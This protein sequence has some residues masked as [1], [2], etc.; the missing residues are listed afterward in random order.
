VRRGRCAPQR[1]LIGCGWGVH[2]QVSYLPPISLQLQLPH[3]YPSTRPP[4]CTLA[5]NWLAPQQAAQLAQQLQDLWQQQGP[6]A[7]IIFEWVDWLRGEA[8]ACLG[9]SDSLHLGQNHDRQQRVEGQAADGGTAGGGGS[10]GGMQVA[11]QILRYDAAEDA[12]A[13]RQATWRCS[14]CYDDVAGDS[15][16]LH[17]G[18]PFRF[19][20]PAKCWALP[21]TPPPPMEQPLLTPPL[22]APRSPAGAASV[23]LPDCHHHFCRTCLATHCSTQLASGAVENLRCPDPGCRLALAPHVLQDLLGQE[24]FARWEELLLQV[25]WWVGGEGGGG[26]GRGLRGVRA[27]SAVDVPAAR[28]RCTGWRG[29]ALKPTH[30]PRRRPSCR[31]R[32]AHPGPHVRRRLLPA[33]RDGVHRGRPKLRPVRAV[34]VRVLLPVQRL[35]A[36][37]QRA[38][39]GPRAGKRRRPPPPI[40]VS[41]SP[42][43]CSTPAPATSACTQNRAVQAQSTLLTLAAPTT[44]V[45]SCP[46]AA[47]AAGATARAQ[48]R[49]RPCAR[50]G[51][52]QPDAL[53][54]VGVRGRAPASSACA[55]L[56][57]GC[58]GVV[59]SVRRGLAPSHR[60]W[61]GLLTGSRGAE[62]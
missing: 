41:S 24:G 1:G 30:L 6:G 58:Q 43:T 40:P 39:H 22:P 14:I 31:P 9:I 52:H 44:P 33:L 37:A 35:L 54:Q 19:P 48:R 60:G 57:P 56:R 7:P 20:N 11:L 42:M 49:Q 15:L 8:L 50:A 18:L 27:A 34:P 38:V 17:T 3:D 2:L 29:T 21:P 13:F 32:A 12:E 36:P 10:P 25:R 16:S 26:C 61:G 23:R 62:V 53:A 4:S 59:V 55:E 46:A 51:P 45:P 5:A 47:A 28:L